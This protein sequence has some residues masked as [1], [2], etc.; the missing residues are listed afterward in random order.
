MTIMHTKEDF[1]IDN[2]YILNY[3]NI[4][5]DQ[6]SLHWIE[7]KNGSFIFIKSLERSSSMDIEWTDGSADYNW[8]DYWDAFGGA[9][10]DMHFIVTEEDFLT[11]VVLEVI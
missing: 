4:E 6:K 1:N 5:H 8:L 7:V 9:I 3:S 11:N 10:D 2:G